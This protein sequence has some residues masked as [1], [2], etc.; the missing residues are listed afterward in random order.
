[1]RKNALM[2]FAV[3]AFA[4]AGIEAAAAADGCGRG[5]YYNG[6]RC[7]T[8]PGAYAEPRYYGGYGGGPL[9]YEP[10]YYRQP[11][12]YGAP[13]PSV[14]RNGALSCN[15]PNYTWQDGACRPYRGPRW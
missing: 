10:R 8:M 11:Q 14:G 15:N 3:L 1:M 7:V 6:Y 2:L 12:Y 13:Y 5:R 4:A 9:T